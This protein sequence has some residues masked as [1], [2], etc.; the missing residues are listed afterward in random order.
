MMGGIEGKRG[1]EEEFLGPKIFED[2]VSG[3]TKVEEVYSNSEKSR[4]SCRLKYVESMMKSGP[5]PES[6]CNK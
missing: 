6:G 3:I 1:D 4:D 5:I 2:L